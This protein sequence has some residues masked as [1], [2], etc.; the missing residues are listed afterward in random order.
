[1][2]KNFKIIVVALCCCLHILIGTDFSQVPGVSGPPAV[3]SLLA[4]CESAAKSPSESNYRLAMDICHQGIEPQGGRKDESMFYYYRGLARYYHVR[5]VRIDRQG[6][7]KSEPF[8]IFLHKFVKQ[9]TDEDFAN[10]EKAI[11]DFVFFVETENERSFKSAHLYQAEIDT[12][13]AFSK[14]HYK[15]LNE[16]YRIMAIEEFE[17]AR[18]GGVDKKLVDE[19]IRALKRETKR[20]LPGIESTGQVR[21]Y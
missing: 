2:R 1:M 16:R 18:M 21:K 10:L 11:I 7:L 20:P 15:A 17:A 4:G 12:M 8:T 6:R 9:A 3:K 19:G 13:L 5:K 14:S